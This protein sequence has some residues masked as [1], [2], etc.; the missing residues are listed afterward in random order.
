M[1]IDNRRIVAARTA[2]A[3]AAQRGQGVPLPELPIKPHKMTDPWPPDGWAAKKVDAFTLKNPIRRAADGRLYTGAGAKGD[4]IGYKKGSIPENW[5]EAALFRTANQGK[6]LEP[7]RYPE[8]NG[9]FP[10]GGATNTPIV[11]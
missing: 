11:K 5:G 8:T 2:N 10:V 6:S 1:S 7:E 4:P 3:Q 9:M